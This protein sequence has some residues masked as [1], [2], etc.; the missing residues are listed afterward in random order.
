MKILAMA[1]SFVLLLVFGVLF[2]A[3][4]HGNPMAGE[5]TALLSISKSQALDFSENRLLSKGQT[6]QRKGQVEVVLDVSRHAGAGQRGKG[7]QNSEGLLEKSKYGFLP[8]RAADGRVPSLIYARPRI[9]RRD[10]LPRIALLITGLGLNQHLSQDAIRK[11]PAKVTLAF[12]AYG[13]RLPQLARQAQRFDHE[14]MLQIPMEPFDPRYSD[15]GPKSLLVS[16]SPSRNRELLH[17]SLGRL[18]GYFGVVNSKGGRFLTSQK[19]VGKLFEELQAR[20]LVFLHEDET[21][22][23][24][25]EKQAQ[26]AG[27]GYARISLS[28]DHKPSPEGINKALKRL[29]ELAIHSG[30]AIGVLHMHPVA[31][32]R[33]SVW[34]KAL[35]HRRIRLV[36]VSTAY[37]AGIGKQARNGT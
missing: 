19:A 12:S 3:M 1:S 23:P 22:R 29:E 20:G 16:N 13:R 5:P 34:A 32:D 35:K 8:R 33:V 7:L 10:T 25:T 15:S 36:P 9:G 26:V 37:P 14:Y 28:I 21:A 4:T 2:W 11:L 27:L 24:L 6:S 17:W 30:F 31:I 18:T